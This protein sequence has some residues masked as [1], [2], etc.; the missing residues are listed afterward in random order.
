MPGGAHR[1]G[2]AEVR[3]LRSGVEAVEERARFELG[4][5]KRDEV[6]FQFVDP[7]KAPGSEA[8]APATR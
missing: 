5:V 4:M 2:L 3:D 7:A 6:F 8:G 1:R